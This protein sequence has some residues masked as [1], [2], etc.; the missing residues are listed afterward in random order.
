MLLPWTPLVALLARRSIYT[1]SRKR[2]LLLWLLFGLV[3]FS[4]SKNKLPGYLLPLLPPA[5]V[6]MG[7]SLAESKRSRWALP[8]AALCLVAIPIA[9]P[10]LPEALATGISRAS[11]PAFRLTWLLPIALAAAVYWLESREKRTATLAAMAIALTAGL[12]IL[13]LADLP[14]ID[15]AVSARPVWREIADRRDRVCVASMHRSWRYGLNYYSIVP[16]PDCSQAPRPLQIRQPPGNP[17][18]IRP[19]P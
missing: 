14:A 6:L 12:Y 18:E 15:R 3:F 7:S 9:A 17:P 16:L 5:A 10:M 4:L 19:R 8:A 1:D 2:F 11:R 13:K